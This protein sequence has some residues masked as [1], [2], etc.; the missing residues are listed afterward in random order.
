MTAVTSSAPKEGWMDASAPRIR[1]RGFRDG[2]QR[3]RHAG[4]CEGSKKD[5]MGP[6]RAGIATLGGLRMLCMVTHAAAG[7]LDQRCKDA[8]KQFGLK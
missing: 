5:R 1:V 4:T 3:R 6:T 2:D 7:G 8:L